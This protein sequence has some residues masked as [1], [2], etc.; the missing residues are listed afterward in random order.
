VRHELD[1]EDVG[2]VTG[3]DAGRQSELG[4]RII[5]LVGVNVDVLIIGS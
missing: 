1:G 2:L 4:V 3:G 5:G